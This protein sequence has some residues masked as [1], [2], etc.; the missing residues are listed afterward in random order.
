MFGHSNVDLV[1]AAFTADGRLRSNA[2][3]TGFVTAKPRTTKDIV[4]SQLVVSFVGHVHVKVIWGERRERGRE[5]ERGGER[6]EGAF[7]LRPFVSSLSSLK[8]TYAD[9]H[10][11]PCPALSIRT[12][13]QRL[14]HCRLGGSSLSSMT[15][16]SRP[17]RAYT[18]THLQQ[19]YMS[20]PLSYDIQT[21][22]IE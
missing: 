7:L 21:G 17:T 20:P 11:W 14:Y 9:T 8:S 3:V 16:S 18:H 13:D 22:K 1:I 15:T 19:H 2:I 12:R 4:L 5:R 6:R 10:V